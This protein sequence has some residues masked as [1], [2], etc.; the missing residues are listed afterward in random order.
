MSSVLQ[1]RSR[2][3]SLDVFLMVRMARVSTLVV[4]N[5]WTLG[6][7]KG[8]VRALE[9]ANGVEGVRGWLLSDGCP[10]PYPYPLPQMPMRT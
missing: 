10:Y 7:A 4:W 8:Y 2:G 5:S 3:R 9:G 1:R 6:W